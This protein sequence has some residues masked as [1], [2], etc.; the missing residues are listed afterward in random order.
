M[1]VDVG[2]RFFYARHDSGIAMLL[3]GLLWLACLRLVFATTLSPAHPTRTLAPRTVA[4]STL[5]PVS[6]RLPEGLPNVRDMSLLYI[7]QG[8]QSQTTVYAM[9]TGKPDDA[10]AQTHYMYQ[11]QTSMQFNHIP[12]TSSVG[13][14]ALTGLFGMGCGAT[15]RN[16]W[17]CKYGY[18]T[19]QSTSMYTTF[20]TSM[21]PSVFTPVQGLI[22]SMRQATASGPSSPPPSV[23]Q[24]NAGSPAP[25]HMA[26]LCL[27][28]LAALLTAGAWLL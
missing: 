13:G 7:G 10:N 18:E 24:S 17:V 14:Q 27:A 22:Q 4:V 9:V 2:P 20:T 6:V 16:D 25:M 26:P 5:S 12:L 23:T 28:L 11:D 8:F 3:V 21:R 19:S 1:E 15:V